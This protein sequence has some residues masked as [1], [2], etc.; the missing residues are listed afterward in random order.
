MR[1][2]QVRGPGRCFNFITFRVN[3]PEGWLAVGNPGRTVTFHF[4]AWLKGPS[5][6]FLFYTHHGH[7]EV[8]LAQPI[9][10]TKD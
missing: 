8:S 6:S 10:N 3:P 5:S 1:P 4:Q 2:E 9:W 7:Q